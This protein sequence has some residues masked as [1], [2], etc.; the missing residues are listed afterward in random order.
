[1]MVIKSRS[2]SLSLAQICHNTLRVARWQECRAEGESETNGL[3]VCIPLLRQM[4]QGTERL[5]EIP[6]SLAV[7]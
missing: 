5:L 1:M 6:D 2:Q 3:L 7:G 4:R